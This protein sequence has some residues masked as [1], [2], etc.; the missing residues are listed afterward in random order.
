MFSLRSISLFALACTVFTSAAP[1]IN[2]ARASTNPLTGAVAALTT[3]NGGLDASQLAGRGL[4]DH[5]SFPDCFGDA[6]DRLGPIIAS[7]G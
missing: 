2:V 3:G 5:K 6:H 7:L 4:P 1:A